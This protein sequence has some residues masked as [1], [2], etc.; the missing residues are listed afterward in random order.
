[1]KL[2]KSCS[3]LPIR[4]FHN[5][6]ETNDL[7]NLVIDF[8][9]ENI[10]FE[11]T[12]EQNIEFADI[13]ET[14]YYEYSELSENH[15]LRRTLKKRHL[16]NDWTFLYTII[17]SLVNLYIDY[18]NTSSL[19]LINEI[20]EPKYHIKLDEP[21]DKQIIALTN[22]MKGLKNKIKIAKLK[23]A[24]SLESNKKQVKIDLDRDALYLERNLELKR[25][26]DPNITP[27]ASWVKMIQMS[28]EKAKD[29][30][31]NTNNNSRSRSRH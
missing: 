12:E 29:Y 17:T 4:R 30:A 15:K 10:E 8:D 21:I 31:R 23:L 7:R 6:I 19:T 27:V 3:T 25:S 28:K 2:Y 1:M 5:I 13:F 18:G 22:K 16:I 9:P 20:N 24:K 26:I 14:I 11:L